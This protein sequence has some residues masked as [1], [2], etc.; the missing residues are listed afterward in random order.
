MAAIDDRKRSNSQAQRRHQKGGKNQ[1]NK[2]FGGGKRKRPWEKNKSE[3]NKQSIDLDKEPKNEHTKF[4]SDDETDNKQSI[5][6][7]VVKEKQAENKTSEVSTEKDS[8]E[9]EPKKQKVEV[10]DWKLNS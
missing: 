1:R 9:V 8:G 2:E 4:D 10:V 6:S 7:E 5:V 3:K